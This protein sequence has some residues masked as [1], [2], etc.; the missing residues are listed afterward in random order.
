MEFAGQSASTY[1]REG[2]WMVKLRPL[3]ASNQPASMIVRGDNT[4]TIHNLLVGEVWVCSGQSNMERQLGPRNG[5]PLIEGWQQAAA[6]ANDPTLREFQVPD[7][8]SG[9]PITAARGQWTVC[10]P[11]TAPNFCAVGFFFARAL[12]ADRKVPVGL[13]WTTWGGTQVEAWT[14]RDGL[15]SR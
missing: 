15:L 9:V 7:F 5:Q 2:K 10:T 13:L 4:V 12:Q 3:A 11:Q 1:A 14:G 6:T 8:Q